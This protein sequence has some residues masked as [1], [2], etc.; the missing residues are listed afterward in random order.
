MSS[1]DGERQA[2]SAD[3]PAE[4]LD[5]LRAVCRALPGAYEEQAWVGTRWRVRAR[6]FAHVL[7]VDAGWPPAY[8]RAAGTDGPTVVLTFESSGDELHALARIGDPFF[9]PPWRPT[10]VGM[11][12]DGDVDW[13]EIAEFVTESYR[14]Q[15]AVRRRRG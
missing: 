8:A 4:T 3:V 7:V 15:E 6:T 10:V 5:E 13:A 9:K 14:L 2:S 11:R 12:L 1:D